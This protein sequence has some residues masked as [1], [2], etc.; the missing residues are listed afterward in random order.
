VGDPDGFE[1]TALIRQREAATRA[2]RQVIVALTAHAMGGDRDRCL[3]AG[4]DDYLSKPFDR[5]QLE[6]VLLRWLPAAR[7]PQ[8]QNSALVVERV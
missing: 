5:D 4:M 7:Q 1:A 8:V 6:R 2:Q 3:E